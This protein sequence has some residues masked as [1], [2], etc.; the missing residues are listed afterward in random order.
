MARYTVM[1]T[2]TGEIRVMSGVLAW[3]LF[4]QLRTMPRSYT[5]ILK[6]RMARSS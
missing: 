3:L 1:D 5:K 2:K 4:Q 6:R